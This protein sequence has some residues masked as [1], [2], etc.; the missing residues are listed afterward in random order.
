MISKS[1]AILLGVNLTRLKKQKTKVELANLSF[2]NTY[3]VKLTITIEGVN[4][5]IPVLIADDEV[6]C[7]LGRKGVFDYFDVMF[8]EKEKVIIFSK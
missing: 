2:I 8:K 7:L 5:K 1:S 3:K 6:E 4:L